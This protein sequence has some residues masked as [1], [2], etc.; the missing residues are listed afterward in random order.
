MDGGMDCWIYTFPLTPD[1]RTLQVIQSCFYSYDTRTNTTNSDY[2][3]CTVLCCIV[4]YCIALHC[5]VLRCIV[6]YLYM[7]MALLAVYVNQKRRDP[8]RRELPC[9]ERS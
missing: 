6:L 3:L 9:R 2:H 4:L 1:N 7:H 8:E 5:I